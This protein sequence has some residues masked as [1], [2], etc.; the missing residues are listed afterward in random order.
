MQLMSFFKSALLARMQVV[1]YSYLGETVLAQIV[2]GRLQ[3]LQAELTERYGAVL[4][5]A[6]SVQSE[7]RS[8]YTRHENDARMLDASID[9]ELFPPLSLQILS[10]PFGRRV[11]CQ[12]PA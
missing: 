8:R 1:P 5:I 10:Q 3:R 4:D 9:G 12:R 6:E 7:L 11:F 2:D